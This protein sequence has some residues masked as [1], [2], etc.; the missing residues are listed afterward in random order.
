MSHLSPQTQQEG[1]NTL[2]CTQDTLSATREHTELPLV[3]LQCPSSPL[4]SRQDMGDVESAGCYHT[5]LANECNRRGSQMPGKD[6][7]KGLA[8]LWS[9]T[10]KLPTP[11]TGN[12]LKHMLIFLSTSLSQFPKLQF[13][14]NT[15]TKII[16]NIHNTLTQLCSIEAFFFFFF[17]ANLTKELAVHF[18]PRSSL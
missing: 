10:N 5:L 4:E 2:L 15:T 11:L 14:N 1:A 13:Q 9:D 18:S 17:P 12:R 6:F 8:H 16:F 3:A 7:L